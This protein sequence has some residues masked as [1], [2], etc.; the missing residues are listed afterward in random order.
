MKHYSKLFSAATLATA[1]AVTAAVCST[2]APAAAD[3][4]PG[5][6][7]CTVEPGS[8]R[9]T[10]TPVTFAP[11]PPAEPKT[12]VAGFAEKLPDLSF[13]HFLGV[14]LIAM[15]LIAVIGSRDKSS[16][17]RTMRP[18]TARAGAYRSEQRS[19]RSFGWFGI[20]AGIIA[21]GYALGGVA[22]LVIG[23]IV[24]GLIILSALKTGA[25]ADEAKTGYEAADQAWRHDVEMTK[26]NAQMHRPDPSRY[27]PFGLGLKPPPAPG[28]VLPPEPVMSDDDALRFAR[29]GSAVD[30]I[31]GSAASALVARD[32]SWATAETA[33]IAACKAA[34]L[35]TTEQR[36]SRVPGVNGT[37]EVFVPGADLVRVEVQAEGD[38]AVVV[39]PRG[40]NVGAEQLKSTTDFFL[41]TARVRH[42]GAW[43]W[44]HSDDTFSLS[45][46][47]RDLTGPEQSG[48]SAPRAPVDDDEDW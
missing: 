3:P 28:P 15:G 30:L 21:L 8:L 31:P 34:G 20:G 9:T 27:D 39:K 47:N 26:L 2:A 13:W 45:L 5:P 10:C 24:G 46:S 40:L 14:G 25:V 18:G 36:T 44:R 11:A 1:L 35:G 38:A 16:S 12:G 6:Q 7:N 32:G 17:S 22:G 37:S 41:R 33:W 42:A 48:E 23:G 19:E 29:L 43:Y 4:T